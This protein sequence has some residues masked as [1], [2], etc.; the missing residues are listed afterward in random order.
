MAFQ[1]ST[2]SLD[3]LLTRMPRNLHLAKALRLPQNACLSCELDLCLLPHPSQ[4]L[5]LTPRKRRPLRNLFLTF[6]EELHLPR[7]SHLTLRKCCARHGTLSRNLHLT[8]RKLCACHEIC[9]GWEIFA[10]P[11]EKAPFFCHAIN[12]PRPRNQRL[13]EVQMALRKVL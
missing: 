13:L 2:D 4:N 7:H 9:P 12:D 5:H 11:L 6:R 1:I 10:S 8:S 3:K